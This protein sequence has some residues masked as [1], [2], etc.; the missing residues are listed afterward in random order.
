MGLRWYG[1]INVSARG[2]AGQFKRSFQPMEVD[3]ATD[4]KVGRSR[5]IGSL[6]NHCRS[7]LMKR[8]RV[9]VGR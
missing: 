3:V 8:R 5:L 6:K 1:F 4:L 7:Y 9:A 2:G